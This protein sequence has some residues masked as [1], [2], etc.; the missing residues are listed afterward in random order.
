VKRIWS[1]ASAAWVVLTLLAAAVATLARGRTLT[2]RSAWPP[3]ADVLYLPSSSTLRHMAL[4]HSEL[5]ADLLAVRTNVYFGTQLAQKGGQL[6]LARYLDAAVDLDPWFKQLYPIGAAMLI[7]NGRAISVEAVEGANALLRR[8]LEV[9]PDDW[10]L[11]FQVGFNESFELPKLVGRDDPRIPAWRQKGL[12]AMQRATTL[13]DVP[14]WLPS[15]AAR[16]L[17]K[18]GQDDL[19]IK[20]LERAFA[21]TSHPETQAQI[22]AKLRVLHAAQVTHRLSAEREDFEARVREGFDYTPE[23]FNVLV[24]PRLTRA[25]LPRPAGPTRQGR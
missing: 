24:G 9:F 11:W 15:L 25:P 13:P 4:G 17:T 18:Q 22:L 7:Y 14:H 16:M 6:W 2:L 3:E 1:E 12:E 5:A 20:H 19:A 10:D 23:A 21:A 8:G